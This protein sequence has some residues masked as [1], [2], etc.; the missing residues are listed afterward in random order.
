MPIQSLNPLTDEVI[1]EFKEHSDGY[2]QE[3]LTRAEDTYEC[4]KDFTV[5]ERATRVLAAARQLRQHKDRYAQLMTDE[6]GKLNREAIAEV[7]KCALACDYYAEHAAH[8]LADEPLSVDEGD[9]YI[10]YDPIGTVL[11]VMP[12]NYPFWQVIRFAIPNLIAGNVGLLKHASNVP[13]CALALEELFQEAGFPAGA[14]QNLFISNKQ[15]AALL[16]DQRVKAATL[17]GSERAGSAVAA[18]GRRTT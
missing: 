6:M 10:A 3:A 8:F 4:W 13:Q 15:V 7:E 17:T 14:F 16:E 5:Q 11:A 12:W 2:V 18:K 9:A 1:Q